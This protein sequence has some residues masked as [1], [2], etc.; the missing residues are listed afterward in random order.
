M[1][2]MARKRKYSGMKIV[3]GEQRNSLRNNLQKLRCAVTKAIEYR[4]E[5]IG[6]QNEKVNLLKYD[7]MNGP[8]HV[9]ENHKN[10][11]TYICKKKKIKKNTNCVLKM[12][13]F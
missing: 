3:L 4:K 11:T 5:S 9:Y 2:D 8:Y 12:E 1:R 7:I 13:K 6:I 10:C